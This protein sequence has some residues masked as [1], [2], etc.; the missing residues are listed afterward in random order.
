MRAATTARSRAPTRVNNGRFGRALSFEGN[1][2]IVKVPD[3]PSLHLGDGMTLEAWVKP[4]RHDATG[5]R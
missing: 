2:D 4:D 5:A 1:D 3:D